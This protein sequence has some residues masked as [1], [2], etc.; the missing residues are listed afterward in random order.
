MI[1]IQLLLVDIFFRYN[2]DMK[3][4]NQSMIKNLLHMFTFYNLFRFRFFFWLGIVYL[5]AN[6]C[7][8]ITHVTVLHL[9]HILI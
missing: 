7:F 9:I 3:I 5:S 4:L 1:I 8:M 2:N 6:A